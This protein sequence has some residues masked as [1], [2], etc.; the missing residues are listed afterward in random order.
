MWFLHVRVQLQQVSP[1]VSLDRR[2]QF[3][4]F[5]GDGGGGGRHKYQVTLCKNPPA[6]LRH[7]KSKIIEN[8]F[9]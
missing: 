3:Y 7:G 9:L 1:P 4:V 8:H 6:L 2:H 5:F